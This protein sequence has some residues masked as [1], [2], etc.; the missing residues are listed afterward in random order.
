[1]ADWEKL[2]DKTGEVNEFDAEDYKK[3]IGDGDDMA[4]L[5]E[6]EN[7]RM[8]QGEQIPPTQGAT[9]E[10]NDRHRALIMSTNFKQ[11]PPE[12][13]KI[14]VIH[15]EGELKE[16]QVADAEGT[17]DQAKNINSGLPPEGE[18]TAPPAQPGGQ[19]AGQPSARP[20]QQEVQNV[21]GNVR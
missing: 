14:I 2:W 8:M 4:A 1:M 12:I 9:L 19:P 17:Y 6:E 3:P 13:Q 7:Q 16:M 18:P 20:A 15:Y 21:Q 11:M 10:H 5:G